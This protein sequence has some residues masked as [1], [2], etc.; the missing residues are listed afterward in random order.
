M[1]KTL[2]LMLVLMLIFALTACNTGSNTETSMEPSA[3]EEALPTT[4]NTQNNTEIYIFSVMVEGV[5]DVTEFNQDH[6]NDMDIQTVTLT[7]TKND[8]P[9]DYQCTGVIF[10]EV[11]SALGATDYTSVTVVAV[12]GYEKTYDKAVIEEDTTFF[13]VKVDGETEDCPQTIAATMGSGYTIKNIQ[14]LIVE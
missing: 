8:V 6:Y 5:E 2:A 12:D 13:A 11:L 7:V 9:T 4:N 14:K 1:R 3:S 10:Q